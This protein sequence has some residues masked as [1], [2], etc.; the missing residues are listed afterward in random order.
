MRWIPPRKVRDN[1]DVADFQEYVRDRRPKYDIT[2]TGRVADSETPDIQ[3]DY[4]AVETDIS[5]EV[6]GMEEKSR[7]ARGNAT[8]GIMVCLDSRGQISRHSEKLFAP[9]IRLGG[10]Y[11]TFWL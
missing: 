9:K 5:N 3:E 7:C 2:I 11:F 8:G 4:E 1:G 6:L 10:E